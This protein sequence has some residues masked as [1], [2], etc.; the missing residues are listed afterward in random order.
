MIRR[1][2][3][4]VLLAGS[5]TLSGV[6]G[7]ED[8]TGTG[9]NDEYVMCGGFRVTPCCSGLECRADAEGVLRCLPD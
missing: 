9:C 7:C 4:A 8:A 5:I 2:L 3:L 1:S 6:S